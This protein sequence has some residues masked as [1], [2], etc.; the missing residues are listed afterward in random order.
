LV[1]RYHV[2]PEPS[3][4]EG[5]K[6][7]MLIEKIH[8]E[9]G[10][11]G[12]MRTLVK[13]KKRFLWHDITEFVKKFIKICEKC[14]LVEQSENM[15]SSLKE[16]KNIPI[17]NLFYHVT[18]DIARPLPN[19]TNGNKDVLVAIDHYYK[20]YEAQFFKQHDASIVAK[21]LEDEVICR[22]G[23]LKYILTNN[24]SE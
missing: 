3:G 2:F 16:M 8:K 23:V 10:H 6:K 7:R 1:R 9:I 15:K 14:Q 12:E 22:Y 5:Y 17:C 24:G 13:V 11:F 20:W 21:F 19:S 18:M 4:T